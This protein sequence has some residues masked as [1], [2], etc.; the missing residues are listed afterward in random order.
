[1][2]EQAYLV[3]REA[4]RNAVAHPG[5]ARVRVSLEVEDAELRGR[6]ED[7]GA[8][9]DSGG[10][11][12]GEEGTS[13]AGMGLLSMRERTELLGGRLEI[14]SGPGRGTTVEVRMPLAD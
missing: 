10:D 13:P 1:M 12:G 14:I 11:P 2:G 9:F 8:G 3:I 6:V 4:V 7:D 5:C